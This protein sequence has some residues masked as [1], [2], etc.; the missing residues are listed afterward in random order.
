MNHELIPQYNVLRIS[1]MTKKTGM[2]RSAIY[3]KLDL[4][5]KYYDASFPKPIHVGAS[6]VGWIEAEVDGWL[7]SRAQARVAA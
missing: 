5:G 6:T 2:S 3:Y 4:G 7:A 1:G